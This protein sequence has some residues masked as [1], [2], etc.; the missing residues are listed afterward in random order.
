MTCT[1][2]CNSCQAGVCYD[3]EGGD[4]FG[5]KLAYADGVNPITETTTK[6]GWKNF[7]NTTLS[8]VEGGG[9]KNN[10]SSFFMVKEW[11]GSHATIIRT[12]LNNLHAS[13]KRSNYIFDRNGH[14]Y[15]IS[16]RLELRE[17]NANTDVNPPST[18]TIDDAYTPCRKIIVN[19]LYVKDGVVNYE[20][21][22]TANTNGIGFRI[23]DEVN[24]IQDLKG[25]LQSAS[26]WRFQTP[27]DSEIQFNTD[28]TYFIRKLP[29]DNYGLFYNPV[30]RASF[31][32]FYNKS[33]NSGKPNPA[34][35]NT[36]HNAYCLN[37]SIDN[38]DYK[39]QSSFGDPTC[40]CAMEFK[41][42]VPDSDDDYTI[43]KYKIDFLNIPALSGSVSWPKNPN[44]VNLK[45]VDA[46]TGDDMVNM[47]AGCFSPAC[48]SNIL[49]LKDDDGNDIPSRSF[50]DQYRKNITNGG[51]ICEEAPS[52]TINQCNTLFSTGDD[53]IMNLDNTDITAICGVQDKVESECLVGYYSESGFDYDNCK[54]CPV[55]TYQPNGGSKSC[56][57]CADGWYTNG[58]SGQTSCIQKPKPETDTDTE[59]ETETLAKNNQQFIII[60]LAAVLVILIMLIIFFLIIKK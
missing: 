28:L 45:N 26:D 39:D 30:H 27:E 23:N 54:K 16:D 41:V 6:F 34:A 53:A 17:L 50:M 3:Q 56:I 9:F 35:F 36:L 2:G 58:Q 32:D 12:M 60:A 55:D 33:A 8:S 1:R 25:S 40:G 44:P 15:K 18:C 11:S 46:L 10:E 21:G 38:K 13:K 22:V 37:T 5:S 19:P 57:P 14:F 51:D 29:D 31:K 52:I 7:K 42:P 48:N 20:G 4:I 59:T 24:T 47:Y 43:N 49:R